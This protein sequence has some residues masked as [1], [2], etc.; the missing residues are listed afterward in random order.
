MQQASLFSPWLPGSVLPQ[1]GQEV[2]KYYERNGE[3]T[4][5]IVCTPIRE[6]GRHMINGKSVYRPTAWWMPIP[7][8][9][10]KEG[11]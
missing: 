3:L 2:L 1:P 4:G 10:I 5:P 6:D 11:E 9:Q 8:L 7:E